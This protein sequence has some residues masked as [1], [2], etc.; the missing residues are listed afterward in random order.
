MNLSTLIGRKK[1][2]MRA[3]NQTEVD[4]LMGQLDSYNHSQ[5][6]YLREESQLL[7]YVIEAE[8]RP[9]AG[10]VGYALPYQIGYLDTLFVQQEYRGKGLG[11]RLLEQLEQAMV[12]QGISL[13]QLATY[14][15]QAPD[16][17]QKHGYRVFGHLVYPQAGV[18]EYF[19]VKEIGS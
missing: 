11:T 14:D 7:S 13:I 8:G 18:E 17:Y 5:K 6:P 3:A 4:F 10:I 1:E 12:Q 9:V 2:N 15:F 16:F 19:L